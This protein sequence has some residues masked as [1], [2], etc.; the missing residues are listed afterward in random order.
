M[1]AISIAILIVALCGNAAMAETV[2]GKF[3]VR[4]RNIDGS[5][6]GGTATISPS[7]DSTCRIVWKTGSTSNG[8]CM[9]AGNA[10]AAA[11]V[12]NKSFG[13]VL[14]ELQGDGSLKGVWTIADQPGSGTETL[15]PV[16]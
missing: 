2:G 7:S 15:T 3:T 4:G 6:Y 10:F 14:Y 13:L 5:A 12:L 16:K 1:R 9:L 8:I 11:Y